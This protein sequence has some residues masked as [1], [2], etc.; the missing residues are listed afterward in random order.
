MFHDLMLEGTI[1]NYDLEFNQML[2]FFI[3]QILQ[4]F[5]DSTQGI[6]LRVRHQREQSHKVK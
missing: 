1:P 3:N 5:E 6:F 2:A 4:K